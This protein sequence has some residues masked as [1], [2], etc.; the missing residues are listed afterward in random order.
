MA[1]LNVE[2]TSSAAVWWLIGIVVLAVLLWLAFGWGSQ[3]GITSIPIP[4]G[5]GPVALSMA[6]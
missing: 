5:S 1:D 6:A 4:E 2:R 3:E